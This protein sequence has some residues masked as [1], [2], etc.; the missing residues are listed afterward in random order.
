MKKPKTRYIIALVTKRNY[1]QYLTEINRDL[2]LTAW[3]EYTKAIDF[4][5][6]EAKEIIAGLRKNGYDAIVIREDGDRLYYNRRLFEDGENSC[7]V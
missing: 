3:E 6:K 2:R 1:I 5:L 7:R 4:S